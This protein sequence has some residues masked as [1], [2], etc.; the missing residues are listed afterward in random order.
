MDL[1]L[2]Y[3][4]VI[5]ASKSSLLNQSFDQEYRSFKDASRI[6][7]IKVIDDTNAYA[8]VYT[9]RDGVWLSNWFNFDEDRWVIDLPYGFE[10][11]LPG[12]GYW[13]VG[14]DADTNITYERNP[15]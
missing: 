3:R 15:H 9:F 8:S 14:F 2:Y 4:N 7:E 10:K 12:E 5:N 6:E 13:T 1:K 11:M